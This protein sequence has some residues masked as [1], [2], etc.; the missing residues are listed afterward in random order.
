MFPRTGWGGVLG[1]FKLLGHKQPFL[2]SSEPIFESKRYIDS[3]VKQKVQL[4]Q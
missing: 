3:K 2:E 1:R 4:V